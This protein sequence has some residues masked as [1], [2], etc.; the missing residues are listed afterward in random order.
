ME[1]ITEVVRHMSPPSKGVSGSVSDDP[2][3]IYLDAIW[4]CIWSPV[5]PSSEGLS[6]CISGSHLGYIR[7]SSG[8]SIWKGSGCLSESVSG[9]H[10]GVYL[11]V[12]SVS[13]P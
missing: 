11:D 3:E 13:K 7:R 10:L 8:K 4:G 2:L 12:I 5:W 6:G 1:I 9:E